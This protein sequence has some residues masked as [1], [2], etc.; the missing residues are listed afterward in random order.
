MYESLSTYVT[1]TNCLYFT[2]AGG[3]PTKTSS[4]LERTADLFFVSL[5]FSESLFELRL[6]EAFEKNDLIS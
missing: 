3:V 6:L 1:I 2:L 5:D 4:S